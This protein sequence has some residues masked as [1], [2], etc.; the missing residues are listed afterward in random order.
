MC[1]LNRSESSRCEKRQ[2]ARRLLHSDK[3]VRWFADILDKI[4]RIERFTAGFDLNRFVGDERA[5]FAVLHALMIISEAARRLGQNAE[6][7]A[8]GQLWRAIR[9]LGNVLRHEYEG[10]DMG[11]IRSIISG[12][13]PSLKRAVELAPQNLGADKA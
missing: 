13:L 6:S 3:R 5:S 7:F 1:W 12:D 10:V 9:G 2:S 8:T 4:A 11:E